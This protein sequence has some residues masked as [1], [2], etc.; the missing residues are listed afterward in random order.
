MQ[1]AIY[2]AQQQGINANNRLLIPNQL[3]TG[4]IAPIK[5][6]SYF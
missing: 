2:K 5:N 4:L 6:V 1:V 3:C